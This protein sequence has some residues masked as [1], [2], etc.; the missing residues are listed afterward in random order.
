MLFPR[1][2]KDS[3]P[4]LPFPKFRELF[5]CHSLQYLYINLLFHG[6]GLKLST[7]IPAIVRNCINGFVTLFTKVHFGMHL[8]PIESIAVSA[9][10]R[11]GELSYLAPLGSENISTP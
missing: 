5:N 1:H 11:R 10:G 4:P 2:S 9:V 8:L 7:D 6:T 3:S